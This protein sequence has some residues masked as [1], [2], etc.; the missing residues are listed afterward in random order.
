MP[1]S[2]DGLPVKGRELFERNEY[3]NLQTTKESE[4]TLISAWSG[5]IKRGEARKVLEC[6]IKAYGLG[7]KSIQ[8]KYRAL[9]SRH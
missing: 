3:I 4:R 1:L 5:V 8:F 2:I 6:G 9:R 7:Y